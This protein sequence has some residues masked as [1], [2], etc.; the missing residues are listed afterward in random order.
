MRYYF[1]PTRM[2]IIKKYWAISS[3]NEDIE[4]LEHTYIVNG[5]VKMVQPF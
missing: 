3:V 4:K 5:D 1:A 2:A